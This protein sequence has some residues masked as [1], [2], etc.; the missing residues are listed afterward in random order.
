[1]SATF[2]QLIKKI[3]GNKGAKC[4][5]P[6]R[7][8]TYGKGCQ[9]GCRYCYSC[10]ILSKWGLWQKPLPVDIKAVEHLFYTIF[11]TDK[12]HRFRELLESR[13]RIRLGGM[14]DVFMTQEKSLG[15]TKKFLTLL[16]KYAIPYLIITKSDLIATPEYMGVLRKD[17]A[18]IQFTVSSMNNSLVSKIEPGA[19]EP[20]RRLKAMQTLREHGF[21][22]NLRVAPIILDIDGYFDFKA[23]G[24]MLKY[25]PRTAI[26]EFLRISNFI[27]GRIRNL[28]K[29]IYPKF[30]ANYW[31]VDPD[32][33]FKIC[34]EIKD[35]CTYHGIDFS[36]CD[37]ETQFYEKSRQLWSNPDNCCNIDEKGWK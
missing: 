33:K 34:K 27:H 35:V 36:T 7:M 28:D 22:S 37:E 14:C 25:T 23:F 24:L 13:K 2:K 15:I 3:D 11:E 20:K 6:V 26:I 8:D 19:P 4:F 5:Y 16:G 18:N 29:S 1:M 21:D 17:L 30:H 9:F 31:F 32:L 12:K 10:N